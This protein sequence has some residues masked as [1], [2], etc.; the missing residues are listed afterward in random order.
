MFAV[1]KLFVNYRT[2]EKQSSVKVRFLRLP[3]MLEITLQP[4]FFGGTNKWY[5]ID[6]VC[7]SILSF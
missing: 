6:S 4:R 2:D 5:F 1:A 7:H 3:E